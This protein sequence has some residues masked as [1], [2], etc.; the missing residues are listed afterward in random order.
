MENPF[1]SLNTNQPKLDGITSVILDEPKEE[2][3]E[4]TKVIEETKIEKSAKLIKSIP[5]PPV[6][7]DFNLNKKQ[8]ILAQY[9]GLE[10]NVPVTSPYWRLKG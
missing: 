8:Q 4:E 2:V 7:V 6:K 10:S 5:K 1:K 9:G 3:K